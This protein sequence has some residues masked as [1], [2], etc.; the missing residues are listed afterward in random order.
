M[1]VDN[2]SL[3]QSFR[4]LNSAVDQVSTRNLSLFIKGQLPH[5]QKNTIAWRI[6]QMKKEGLIFHVGRGLYSFETKQEYQPKLS[7]KGKRLY[8]RVCRLMPDDKICAFE[9]AM[10]DDILGKEGGSQLTFLYIAKEKLEGL[11]AEMLDFS[12]K[13][14]LDPSDIIIERYVLPLEEAVILE[15]L[16][17]ETPLLEEGGVWLLTLEGLLVNAFLLDNQYLKKSGRSVEMLFR[18]AFMKYNINESKLL[19][20]AARRD[21]RA[22]LKAF[23]QTIH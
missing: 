19:R 10:I 3:I 15:A 11:F 1:G 12:K 16:V 5:L 13:V 21:K 20:Y 8:N 18:A 22:E 9:L 23:I 7:L 6:S 2:R 17:T 14:F 4:K